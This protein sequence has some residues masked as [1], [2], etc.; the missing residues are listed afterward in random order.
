MKC[1]T[2]IAE[3]VAPFST[4]SV[5]DTTFKWKALVGAPILLWYQHPCLTL[6]Q[7]VEKRS[8]GVLL[9]VQVSFD[10]ATFAAFFALDMVSL[11]SKDSQK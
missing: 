1:I 5:T 3:E 2:T 6:F 11:S 4:I 9:V 10:G 7:C 8:L